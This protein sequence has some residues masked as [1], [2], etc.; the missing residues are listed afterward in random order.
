MLINFDSAQSQTGV[1][2]RSKSTKKRKPKVIYYPAPAKGRASYFFTSFFLTIAVVLCGIGLL[3]ADRNSQRLGWGRD[4]EV[5]SVTDTGKDKG[6]QIDVTVMGNN[7][8]IDTA[9][10]N[11]AQA[12]LKKAGLVQQYIEPVPLQFAEIAATKLCILEQEILKN[13]DF[14]PK[15]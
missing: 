12:V 8:T 9:Y 7:F 14:L 3:V 1:I 11:D 5:F 10:L 2:M 13:C 4:I 15:S 6:K